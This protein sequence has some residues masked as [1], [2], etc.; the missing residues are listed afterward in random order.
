MLGRELGAEGF[1]WGALAGAVLGA[2]GTAWLEARRV[3]ALRL[4]IG[5]RD[6]AL[7]RY[8]AA[9][10]PLV[11]G[12]TLVTVDEWY[13]KWFGA[14][15]AA[16]H[17]RRARLRA[18]ADAAARGRGRSGA[19]DRGAARRSR[20]SRPKAARRSSTARCSARCARV[21]RSRARRGGD[22]WCSPSRSCG[23]STSAGASAPATRERVAGLLQ[24]FAL[25]VPAWIAQQIAV[26][27]FYARGDT[28]RP[29]WLGT[30]IA[31]AAAARSTGR[32][33][34]ATARPGSRWRA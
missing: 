25:A 20:G 2:F 22:A 30:A 7:H 26:R 18:P 10:L 28:W 9:A 8:L 6:P 27:G 29:M 14:R 32:S 24:I 1:A 12:A 16:G 5:L 3:F 21:S 33:A 23:C 34:S 19:R 17:D 31:L 15:L 4:R 11:L 13:D